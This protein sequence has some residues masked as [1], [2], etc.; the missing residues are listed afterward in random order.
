LDAMPDEAF[1]GLVWYGDKRL[2]GEYNLLR[3]IMTKREE[4]KD[5]QEVRAV[6]WIRDPHATINRHWDDEN[7][8]H[9]I[10]PPPPD[11]VL[12]GHKRRVDLQTLIT[13]IVV[14][15]SASPAVFKEVHRL[16]S[17]NGYSIAV[18]PSGLTRYRGLLPSPPR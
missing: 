1:L 4:Y 17:N 3:F 2:N 14:T 6:L 12:P 10:P 9:R 13:E 15:P 5:D 8:P 18:Q 7:R 11:R 16:V